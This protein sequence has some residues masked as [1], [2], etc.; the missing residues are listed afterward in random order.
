MER[1]SS[2]NKDVG[3]EI[4]MIVSSSKL[5]QFTVTQYHLLFSQGTSMSIMSVNFGQIEALLW[6]H[7]LFELDLLLMDLTLLS[8]FIIGGNVN[9]TSDLGNTSSLLRSRTR[10]VYGSISIFRSLSDRGLVTLQGSHDLRVASLQLTRIRFRPL[11]LM[12]EY[13]PLITNSEDLSVQFTLESDWAVRHK[14]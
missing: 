9:S 7:L 6:S 14:E 11:L 1:V 8:F 13:G 4:I 5:N 12:L 10:F 2:V 3:N